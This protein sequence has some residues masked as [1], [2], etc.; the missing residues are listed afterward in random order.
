MAIDLFPHEIGQ[1]MAG[2]LGI[3]PEYIDVY[4]QGSGWLSHERR[5]I[6]NFRLILDSH[7]HRPRPIP[8]PPAETANG[9]STVG[10]M[11]KP[12]HRMPGWGKLGI[13]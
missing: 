7:H 3:G 6:F 13:R 1:T 8:P 4:P 2:K 10:A 9:P 12:L 11:L 5:P